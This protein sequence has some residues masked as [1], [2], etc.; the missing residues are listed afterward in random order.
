MEIENKW[1]AR[2]IVLFVF[3]VFSRWMYVEKELYNLRTFHNCA[4]FE[5]PRE[6]RASLMNACTPLDYPGPDR[7]D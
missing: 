6:Q 1:I 4:M 2:A 5:L 3:A 7:R